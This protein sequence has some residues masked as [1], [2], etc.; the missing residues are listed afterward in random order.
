M[1]SLPNNQLLTVLKSIQKFNAWEIPTLVLRK[2]IWTHFPVV[3]NALCTVNHVK[4]FA[5]CW[6]R[7][8]LLEW[9]ARHN[10]DPASWKDYEFIQEFILMKALRASPSWTVTPAESPDQICVIEMRAAKE[11]PF[12]VSNMVEKS[13][14][15]LLRLN[16]IKT[17]FPVVWHKVEGENAYDIGIHSKKLQ[18]TGI[19]AETMKANL[20][21]ALK[22]STA[23]KVAPATAPNV[24]R[25][26]L[27]TSTIV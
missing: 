15:V 16:D 17:Y 11:L 3:V 9:R 6:H 10:E 20:L 4:R 21:E 1:S 12:K 7:S 22:V 13:L 26:Y 5:V 8:K 2:D 18:L 24:C 23:W 25:I 27:A 19:S 14:P